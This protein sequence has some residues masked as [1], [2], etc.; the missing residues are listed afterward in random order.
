MGVKKA[1][2]KKSK[3]S[4]IGGS[5]IMSAIG[6]KIGATKSR[7]TGKSRRHGANYYANQLL[8]M[9]LKKKI[10]RLKYGGR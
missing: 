9:K 10:N 4:S 6:S 8:I 3:K 1:K 2:T 7:G 5:Q